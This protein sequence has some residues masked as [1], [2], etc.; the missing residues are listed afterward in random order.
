MLG[1]Y[2]M[3]HE[4]EVADESEF[5]LVVVSLW[6]MGLPVASIIEALSGLGNRGGGKDK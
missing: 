4:V 6:L 2:V 1:A 3:Y 5:I